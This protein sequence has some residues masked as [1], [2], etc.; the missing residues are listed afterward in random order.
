MYIGRMSSR[1]S[2]KPA[3]SLVRDDF[4]RALVSLRRGSRL[5][6]RVHLTEGEQV[7]IL[8]NVISYTISLVNCIAIRRAPSTTHG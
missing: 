6:T 1:S 4:I 5:D 7:P 8:P 2:L 3:H